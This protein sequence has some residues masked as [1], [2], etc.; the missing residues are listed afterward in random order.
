MEICERITGS[1]AVVIFAVIPE[2]NREQIAEWYILI[3]FL[4]ENHKK[5]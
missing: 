2:A 4:G 1:T 5:S 3:T